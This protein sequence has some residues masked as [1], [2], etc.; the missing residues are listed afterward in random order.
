[1]S[2]SQLSSAPAATTAKTYTFFSLFSISAN[3]Q[4]NGILWGVQQKTNASTVNAFNATNLDALYTSPL[5]DE[6]LHFVTPMIANGRVYITTKSSVLV[7]GLFNESVVAGG[8]KQ[9]AA[10]GTTLRKPLTVKVTGAY[11]GAVMPGVTINFSDGGA[12]GTFSNPNPVTN[13]SGY[14]E[15][16]YTLPAAPGTYNITAT[17]PGFTTGRFSETAS[18]D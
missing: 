12:G 9:S 18:G 1:V 17:A 13:S 14:A 11:T 10:A 7:M 3:G 6:T 15:T 2:N 8:N 4:N 16:S 5:I